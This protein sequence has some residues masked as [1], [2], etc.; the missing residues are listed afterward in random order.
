MQGAFTGCF[1]KAFS[2]GAFARALSQG[3][4]YESIPREL[5]KGCYCWALTLGAIGHMGL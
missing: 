1:S 3:I 2:L 4:F 5:S